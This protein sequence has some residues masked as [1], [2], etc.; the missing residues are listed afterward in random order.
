M[1]GVYEVYHSHFDEVRYDENL[2]PDW[3][4]L[5]LPLHLI[6]FYRP[7]DNNHSVHSHTLYLM[8]P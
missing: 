4:F 2:L 7:L 8:L 5:L 3:N 1:C 6:H